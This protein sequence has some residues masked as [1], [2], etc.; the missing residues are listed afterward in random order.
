[1]A[2]GLIVAG[3][4]ACGGAGKNARSQ[5]S[6][7]GTASTAS[8]RAPVGD[9]P[10]A[11]VMTQT[12]RDKDSD[13]GAPADDTRNVKQLD[14][15]HA[16]GRDDRRAIEALIERYYAAALAEDGSRACSMLYSTIV[17]ALPE[18]EGQSPPGPPYARG[19]TCQA[20]LTH[21][22]RHFHLQLSAEIAKLKVAAVRLTGRNGL[23]ILSFGSL[24]ERYLS[25]S[26]EGR[27]W[28]VASSLDSELS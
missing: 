25:V 9:I 20:V 2:A 1:M 27:A 14:V 18:D 26:R 10:P 13:V 21:I 6:S 22:F 19:T 15:G 8:H 3:A 7:S 12:D 16:A 24:P 4:P 11:P 28:K 23:V 17:E 5:G